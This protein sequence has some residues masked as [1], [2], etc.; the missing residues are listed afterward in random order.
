MVINRIV[1]FTNDLS[2]SVR[3]G[4]AE[5]NRSNPDMQ[6]LIVCQEKDVFDRN[7]RNCRWKYL[8]KDVWGSISRWSIARYKNTTKIVTNKNIN[9]VG[10]PGHQYE[11]DNLLQSKEIILFRCDNLASE[12]VIGEIIEF[13]PCLGICLSSPILGAKLLSI[14][15]YGVIGLHKGKLP[16]YRGTCHAFWELWNNEKEI[17]CT[18]YKVN[19]ELL[20]GDI[21]IE[22]TVPVFRFSTIKGIQQTL[23][24]LG[25]SLVVKAIDLHKKDNL[26]WKEQ[27]TGGR[28]YPKPSSRQI[29]DLNTRLNKPD[30]SIVRY[31]IKESVFYCYAKLFR[32]IPRRILSTANAQRIVVLLYHRVNDDLR[33]SVTVG[34][35]QFDRHMCYVRQN[36]HVTSIGDIVTGNVPRNTRRPVI[37]ITFDDGYLDNY[38]NAVPILL[39]HKIPA[40][41]FVS[42]GMMG[43]D[44]GFEHD[45]KKLGKALPNM[46]WKQI[47][48]MHQL[49]FTIGSH[50]V[51][52]INC[53]KSAPDLV[54]KEIL[55][56]KSDLN[57]KLGIKEI[58]F[59]YPFGKKDDINQKMLNYV[60]EVGYVGCLSAYG[61]I[62]RKSVD[63]F[64]VL[65]M[66]IDF[67]FT[68]RAFIARLEGYTT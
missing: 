3:K 33:D 58:I 46:T 63:P 67:N 2:Y 7:I 4:I 59:A 49:G 38:V 43:S 27:E 8:K 21:L 48:Q 41:F 18:V 23:N 45:L 57:Q 25:V 15:L 9:L 35:E 36:Y 26:S 13:K 12:D 6:L 54:R 17:G 51:T 61:G 29:R 20:S 66:G 65:R 11:I 16:F 28:V 19:T 5:I 62:I 32:V 1:I 14:P 53:G 60:R 39:K 22:K 47:R 52:H 50:T 64:N 68:D 56:S 44:H 24:E 42:T 30:R 40:A 10:F 34:I 31:L 55:Q 37:C